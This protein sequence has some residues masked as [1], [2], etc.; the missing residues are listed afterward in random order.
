MKLKTL[1]PKKRRLVIS[2]S[3][4]PIVTIIPKR[5]AKVNAAIF[6]A[7]SGSRFHDV[8]RKLKR[9]FPLPVI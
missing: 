8:G 1:S 7:F 6:C 9:R 3:A 2:D 5:I 4:M